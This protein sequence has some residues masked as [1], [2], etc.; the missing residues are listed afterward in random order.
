MYDVPAFDCGER[1]TV[2]STTFTTFEEKG[3]E[4]RDGLKTY[5]DNGLA[6]HP[7]RYLPL[8]KLTPRE[9]CDQFV[10]FKRIKQVSTRRSCE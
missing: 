10:A 8:I 2:R 4:Q 5:R 3:E 9:I 1:L 6:T 7:L